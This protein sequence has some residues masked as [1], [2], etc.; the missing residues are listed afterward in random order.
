MHYVSQRANPDRSDG[1]SLGPLY[2]YRRGRQALAALE[3]EARRAVDYITHD[4]AQAWQN[5]VRRGREKVQQCKLEIHN[6]RTFKRIGNYTPSCIDEKKELAKSERRLNIADAK[7]EAVRHWGRVAEQAFR[8]FQA[9]LAQFISLLDGE[10]PKGV[11]ALDRMLVSLESYLAVQTPSAVR[12]PADE[13]AGPTAACGQPSAPKQ[14]NQPDLQAE[15]ADDGHAVND[16]PLQPAA[17]G[18]NRSNRTV[19]EESP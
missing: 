17:L 1:V 9:R 19:G 16:S 18:H 3:M 5:E 12:E 4:Q 11:C 6:T 2:V 10:L 13:T 8:E 7:V 15:A 14:E